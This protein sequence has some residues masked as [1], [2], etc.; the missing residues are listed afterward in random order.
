MAVPETDKQEIRLASRGN[1]M[2]EVAWFDNHAVTEGQV[3]NQWMIEEK[4]L[5]LEVSDS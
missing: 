3:D 4:F 5:G 1:C 2:L